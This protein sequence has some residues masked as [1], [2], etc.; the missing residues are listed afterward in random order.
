MQ[1]LPS[2]SPDLT[3]ISSF[4]KIQHSLNQIRERECVCV[5]VCVLV[6]DL[7]ITTHV[8]PSKLLG[9]LGSFFPYLSNERVGFDDIH[10]ECMEG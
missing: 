5:H 2:M 3:L 7:P 1:R 10:I 4:Y 9:F 6:L 8:I